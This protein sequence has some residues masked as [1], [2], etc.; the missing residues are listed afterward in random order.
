M[1][2][3]TQGALVA[4][5]IIIA[6]TTV[7]F[8]LYAVSGSMAVLSEAWH[9]FADIATTLLVLVSIIRQQKKRVEDTDAVV[10][11]PSESGDAKKPRRDGILALLHRSY[12]WFRH[13]NTELKIAAAIGAVLFC[14][15]A[16]ILWR[17]FRFVPTVINAPLTTGIIF[18]GLS[19][20]SFFLCRFEENLGNSE[21]SAALIADSHHNRADM[22][23][24]LL[25]GISLII[26]HF[27]VNL[28][29]WVCLLIAGY[30]LTFS[31]E[32]L[33]NSIR[34]IYLKQ[35]EVTIQYRFTSIVYRIFQPSFYR[36][37]CQQLDKQ[38]QF[39]QR[40]KAVVRAIPAVAR[41]LLRWSLRISILTGMAVYLTT[42]FFT[43]QPDEKALVLRFGRLANKKGA[44]LP[45]IHWKLPY[46][47]DKVIRF[48]TEK[49]QSLAVGNASG[50]STAMIWTK[51]HGD[52]RTFI[53]GDNNLFLPYIV[54]HYRIK[55]IHDYFLTSRD[56]IPEKIL[57]A[58]SYRILNE[59]FAR[60]SFYDLIL[61]K[62]AQWTSTVKDLLQTETDSLHTG[63]E[64]I[65]FHLKDLHPPITLAGAYEDVV[66][67][68]QMK[69]K[70]LNDAER[71]ENSLLSQTRIAMLKTISEAQ[72]YVV[73][74]KSLAEGEATNYLLRYAG[75]QAGGETTRNL[76]LLKNAEK[77][78][79]DKKL[80]LVD[81]QSGVEEKLIYI[82]N[83]MTGGKDR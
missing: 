46:P 61:H 48:Q 27:G 67:A 30:I 3:S 17:V 56:G 83:H 41:W 28:D 23:I 65:D 53:S 76:L 44:L 72:G 68:N 34:S 64:I 78:L 26:Y 49:I 45:G 6:L 7:K 57:E 47:M 79:K 71:Q 37:I 51:E 14:V 43:V 77:T 62:R 42:M 80:I 10:C 15:A 36:P 54:I 38:F 40:F 8:I 82:E 52:T 4:L 59:A 19:F 12:Q 69:A 66:A 39:G 16:M 25:T 21:K 24:S 73:E 70:Y 81:P 60:T 31:S 50:S 58:A 18:I 63:L 20:G 1:K 13:I 74:K 75:Y 35:S 11:P 2:K 32:L 29:R 55:D 5:A 22:A 33:F 9:S